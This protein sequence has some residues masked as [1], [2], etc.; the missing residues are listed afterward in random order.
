MEESII[1]VL[2]STVS[3]ISGSVLLET[4]ALSELLDGN[5]TPEARPGV[6]SWSEGGVAGGVA[7]T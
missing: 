5:W 6:F 4:V 2:E 1:F 3:I 7:G